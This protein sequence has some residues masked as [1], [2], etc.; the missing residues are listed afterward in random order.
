MGNRILIAD[1]NPRITNILMLN[2]KLLGYETDGAYDGRQAEEMVAQVRPDLVI[3]DVMMP[4]RN[5]YQVCRTIKNSPETSH[6]PVVLLSA[7]NASE[8]VS[9]GMD[10]GADAYLCKPYNPKH[11]EETVARLIQ[12]SKE[13]RCGAAWTGLPRASQILEEYNARR[14]QGDIAL[15]EVTLSPRSQDIFTLKYGHAQWRELMNAFCCLLPKV[16]QTVSPY[17]QAG[18]APDNSLLI[19]APA[20]TVAKLKAEVEYALEYAATTYYDDEDLRRNHF[21]Y[22]NPVSGERER[23]PLLHFEWAQ[24]EMDEHGKLRKAMNLRVIRC[25]AG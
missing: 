16:L 21:I 12:E 3:L 11:L 20:P 1:D 5:G 13:G 9:W 22:P 2:F 15:L 24:L 10:C 25:K 17:A 7:K 14:G 19:L 8:D 4:Y 18:Q 6:I 23:I